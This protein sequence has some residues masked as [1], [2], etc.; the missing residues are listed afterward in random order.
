MAN[1]QVLA[2][3][4]WPALASQLWSVR[5]RWPEERGALYPKVAADQVTEHDGSQHSPAEALVPPYVHGYSA[6]SRPG[7]GRQSP[8]VDTAPNSSIAATSHAPATTSASCLARPALVVAVLCWP[9]GC[10]PAFTPGIC[11]FALVCWSRRAN[12]AGFAEHKAVNH[13]S[14]RA[15][16][17]TAARRTGCCRL[18]WPPPRCLSAR[19]TP[20]FELLSC[21]S[22]RARSTRIIGCV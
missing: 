9:R 19:A 3:A 8:G 13:E 14:M 18:R 10:V 11:F 1:R 4:P 5:G 17:T 2:S 21:C 6:A 15:G 7:R 16:R 22:A 12:A 20:R